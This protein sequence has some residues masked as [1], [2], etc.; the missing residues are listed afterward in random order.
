ML[1][2]LHWMDGP[3]LAALPTGVGA[4]RRTGLRI[5]RAHRARPHRPRPHATVAALCALPHA[6]LGGP[7]RRTAPLTK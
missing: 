3:V 5:R 7:A 4:L 2:T 1:W 6:G